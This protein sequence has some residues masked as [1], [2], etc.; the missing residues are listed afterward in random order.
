MGDE[1]GD[2]SSVM[3]IGKRCYVGNLAWKT[4]WQ[5]LK[6]K[7][8]DV[9]NVVYANVMRD[10]GGRSKGWGIVEFET[11]EEAVTAVNTFN[12]TDL[13]GRKI[14]VREDRE[15]RDVKQYNRDNGIDVPGSDNGGGGGGD[16]GGGRGGRSRGRGRRGRGG[17]GRGGDRPPRN[18]DGEDQNG[19]E[20]NGEK[21]EGDGS[22]GMQV[23]VQGIPWKYTWK[24]LRPMFEECGPIDRTEVVYGRDGRSRGYGTVRFET[25]EAA[26]TAIEKFHGSEC[27]GRTLTVKLDQYA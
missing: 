19:D 13:A 18:Q 27:E 23:V 25:V 26:N 21:V 22:S 5:D 2:D 9:G 7:F 8:R 17:R 24:E 12:G 6:D 10:D 14:M 16:G 11:P 1:N 20:A 4:S 3:R 15:D